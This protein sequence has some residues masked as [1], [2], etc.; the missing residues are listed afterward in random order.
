MK[1]LLHRETRAQQPDFGNFVAQQQ[2]P[3]CIG[4]M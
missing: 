2:L 4:N 3:S 1:I